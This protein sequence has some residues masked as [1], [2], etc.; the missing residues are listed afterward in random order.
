MKINWKVRIKN[1]LF[2]AEIGLAILVPIM[3][4]L[5]IAATDFTSWKIVGE[6]LFEAVKNPYVLSLVVVSCFNAIIDPTT[7]GISDSKQAMT[8]TIPKAELE[9]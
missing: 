6:V 8:Y 4:Y 1:P 9:E 3:G 5:G 2:W 7:K